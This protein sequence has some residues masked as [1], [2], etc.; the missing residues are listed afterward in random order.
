[1]ISSSSSNLP[2]PSTGPGWISRRK[3]ILG[4]VLI[5]SILFFFLILFAGIAATLREAAPAGH[6]AQSGVII[7]LRHVVHTVARHLVHHK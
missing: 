2:P 1:M 7:L 5:G 6:P 4:L 3:V